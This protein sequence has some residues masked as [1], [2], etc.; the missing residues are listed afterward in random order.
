M[1]GNPTLRPVIGSDFCTPV[2][3]T[4]QGFPAA[5]NFIFL[6]TH[7][8]F[9]QFGSEHIHSFFAVAQL[10]TLGLANYYHPCRNMGKEYL[11][12]YF[13]YVLSASTPTSGGFHFHVAFFQFKVY[14]FSFRHNGNCC[15]RGMHPSLG[16][17]IGHTLHP[18]YAAL[19]FKRAIYI[20]PGNFYHNLFVATYCSF[21]F[22]NYLRFPSFFRAIAQVHA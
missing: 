22:T 1:I 11:G 19:K 17:G 15:G 2:A 3:R 4:Y 18:V 13:I 21:T 12:F 9:I 20:F 16:F 5:R 8:L 6:L 14:F 7:L 10:R